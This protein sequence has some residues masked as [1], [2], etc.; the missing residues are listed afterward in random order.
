MNVVSLIGN[1]VRDPQ[2]GYSGDMAIAKFT[3]A[4]ND[5][6]GE[7]QRTSYI[8]ITVFGKPAQNAERYL[9][10]GSKVAVTGHIQT[11]S[12]EHDGAKRYVTEVIA[13]KVTYLSTKQENTV[14][15]ENKATQGSEAL[16]DDDV[17]F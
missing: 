15:T 13:D 16:S 1:L 2:L 9:T 10:K 11:G 8:P 14:K 12:Y 6:Y 17:P 5:G 3:I 7:R 4:V